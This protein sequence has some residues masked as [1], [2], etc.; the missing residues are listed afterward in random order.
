MRVNKKN[1]TFAD[2]ARKMP[3]LWNFIDFLRER[4]G[5]SLIIFQKS[6]AAHQSVGTAPTAQSL[7]LDFA[8]TSAG[9]V[10]TSCEGEQTRKLI[11]SACF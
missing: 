4:A 10:A 5:K 6:K 2:T 3:P 1:K 8:M 7:I 9:S 11:T